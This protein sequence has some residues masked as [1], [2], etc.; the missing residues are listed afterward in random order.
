VKPKTI[1]L[2]RR[3]LMIAGIA[4]AAAPAVSLAGQPRASKDPVSEISIARGDTLLVSGRVV[5]A[6]QKPLAGARIEALQ[7]GVAAATDGDGRFVLT[8]TAA[9]TSRGVLC[10]VSHA[11]RSRVTYLAFTRKHR[12]P[13]DGTAVLDRD[14]RGT[15]RTT[16]GLSVA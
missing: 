2:T 10:R 11:G 15:W 3:N 6:A 16:C 13:R 8:A 4:G 14:E 1:S 12:A 5:D 9:R 7:H